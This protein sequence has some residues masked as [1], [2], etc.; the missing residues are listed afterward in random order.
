MSRNANFPA[1]LNCTITCIFEHNYIA[2]S[3]RPHIFEPAAFHVILIVTGP[4]S[5]SRL[6]WSLAI[7]PIFNPK[8]NGRN[9]NRKIIPLLASGTF[10]LSAMSIMALVL[11][12]GVALT[13]A[14]ARGQIFVANDGNGTI[15]E[16]NLDGTTVNASLVS[17]LSYPRDIAIS[18]SDLFVTNEF[19]NA[20]GEYTTSGTTV[21]ASLISL[22]DPFAI[23]VSGQDLFVTSADNGTIAEYDT[24]GNTVNAS[25]ISGYGGQ[26]GMAVSG[27][28]L[29]DASAI[30]GGRIGEYTTSGGTVNP[31]LISSG[32]NDPIGIAVSGPD[33]FVV[34]AGSGTISEYDTSGNI[35][36]ANLVTGL[37]EPVEENEPIG[38]AVSGSDLFVTNWGYDTVGEYTTSGAT[39]NASLVT[40]LDDPWGIAVVVPEPMTG[41]LLLI[42]SACSLMHRRRKQLV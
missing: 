25:L 20:I 32:L 8:R 22:P 41:S 12:A 37:Y 6:A 33:L 9:M 11:W 29:F 3:L 17:G 38:I 16:Y 5:V 15:G 18:G 7:R 23:A 14:T 13:S 42:G 10:S 19:G 24:S 2:F 40:G 4:R 36:N 27:P 30:Y 26:E 1:P 34:N 28:D 21:N 39:V 31:S 35:V